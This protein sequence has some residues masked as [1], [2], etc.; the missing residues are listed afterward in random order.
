[1]FH[2]QSMGARVLNGQLRETRSA[3]GPGREVWE[4]EDAGRWLWWD[5]STL[6]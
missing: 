2:F 4:I 3:D 1:M 5:T 6:R